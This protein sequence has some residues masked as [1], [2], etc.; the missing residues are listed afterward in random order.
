M[1]NKQSREVQMHLCQVLG[2]SSLLRGTKQPFNERLRGP[3]TC[4]TAQ[5]RG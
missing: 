1:L 2:R 4:S 5:H 3:S